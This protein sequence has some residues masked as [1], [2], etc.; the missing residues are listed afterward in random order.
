ML[1]AAAC[2]K[3]PV[4]P[5]G[6]ASV[7]GVSLN[8]RA[9]SLEIGKC[10]QLTATVSPADA[11]DKTVT[12]SS[13][14]PGVAEVSD[15]G[16]VLAVGPGSAVITVTTNDGKKVAKCTVYVKAKA[17]A[18]KAMKIPQKAVVNLAKGKTL[19]V[20]PRLT[21]KSATGTKGIIPKFKSSNKAVAVI[22][23]VGV[24][25]ALKPG[26][27]TITVKAS[28]IRKTFVLNVK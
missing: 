11:K 5:S 10:F 13:S 28:K 26:K 22:D 15:E 16:L 25:T 7:T 14:A 18:L 27:V 1:F 21:P 23:P 4:N 9:I 17:I 3:N 6:T 19:Q 12:W 20:K 8:E 24:I 2:D